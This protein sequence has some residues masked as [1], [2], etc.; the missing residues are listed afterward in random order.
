MLN[1]LPIDIAEKLNADIIIGINLS[2]LNKKSSDIQ[3]IFD[4]LSQ[5]IL[6]NGYKRRIDNIKIADLLISPEIQSYKTIDFSKQSLDQLY[7]NGKKSAKNNLNQLIEIKKSLKIKENNRLKLSGIED[8]ILNIKNIHIESSSIK[9]YNEL[10]P[11]FILPFI[12]KKR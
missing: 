3:D 9:S 7:A 11:N 5:S 10:F 8:D 6:V 12:F 4:V 2:S 1:N